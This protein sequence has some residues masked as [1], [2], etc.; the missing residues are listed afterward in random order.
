MAIIA[1]F[2]KGVAKKMRLKKYL[3]FE[4]N[5]NRPQL[6]LFSPELAKAMYPEAKPASKF[7]GTTFI[8]VTQQCGNSDTAAHFGGLT[9]KK[10]IDDFLN[11]PGKQKPVYLGWGS[12]ISMPRKVLAEYCVRV[13]KHANQRAVVLGGEAKLSVDLLEDPELI[14]FAQENILFVESAPH[15]YLF[16][17]MSAVVHHG[18]AG[19]TTTALRSGRPNIITPVLLDQYDHSRMIRDLGVGAGFK[20]Q[21]QKISWKEL[22]DA[23]FN[24]VN[25]KEM[26][27]R[28]ELLAEKLR[29]ENGARVAAHDIESFWDKYCADGRFPDLFKSSMMSDE[30]KGRTRW[31]LGSFL[32]VAAPVAIA[33]ALAKTVFN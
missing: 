12:M 32:K 33:A 29:A 11:A 3:E 31:S 16:P 24:V 20:R 22:G 8:D 6:F 23:I 5:P 21:M 25:D 17:R 10:I 9:A 27:E 13:A 30:Y 26:L 19:T 4:R 1:A 15:E 28:C 7:V 14:E 2:D 18:G